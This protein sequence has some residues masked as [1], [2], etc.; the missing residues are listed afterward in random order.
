MLSIAHILCL[1]IVLLVIFI[2]TK[3][4]PILLSFLQR[5]VFY[6][7]SFIEFVVILHEIKIR[8]SLKCSG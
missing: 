3:K 1:L 6:I 8:N 5:E 7:K 4:L 2:I